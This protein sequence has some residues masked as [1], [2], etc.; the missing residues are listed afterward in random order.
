MTSAEPRPVAPRAPAGWTNWPTRSV[1]P[2]CRSENDSPPSDMKLHAVFAA[3]QATAGYYYR[4]GAR[5]RLI[6]WGDRN[7]VAYQ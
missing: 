3:P 6:T 5:Y 2:V 4:L 7:I 1:P